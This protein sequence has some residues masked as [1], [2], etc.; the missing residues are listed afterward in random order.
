[1]IEPEGNQ[2][3]FSQINQATSF[4]RLGILRDLAEATL[5]TANPAAS[6]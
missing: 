5:R 1:M 6:F 3:H 2:F 4:E